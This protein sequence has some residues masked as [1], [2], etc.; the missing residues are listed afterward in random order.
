MAGTDPIAVQFMIPLLSSASELA[1][2]KMSIV[3]VLL[4]LSFTEVS[5]SQEQTFLLTTNS[6]E[7]A[8][9]T[10]TP[11]GPVTNSVRDSILSKFFRIRDRAFD[12]RVWVFRIW[13]QNRE[14]ATVKS[15]TAPLPILLS[16]ELWVIQSGPDYAI[17]IA[18]ALNVF[19]AGTIGGTSES[20]AVTAVPKRLDPERIQ[21]GLSPHSQ[22]GTFLLTEFID[23]NHLNNPQ[24]ANPVGSLPLQS[25]VVNKTQIAFDVS[26]LENAPIRMIFNHQFDLVKM[27][28]NGKELEFDRKVWKG[29]HEKWRLSISDWRKLNR[30]EK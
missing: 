22:P 30:E 28:R 24:L 26:F 11:D 9:V 10:F 1:S 19:R 8:I 21:R 2:R 27:E 18:P 25:I 15:G 17:E 23:E 3:A 4:F 29:I 20:A 6:A 5:Q 16:E 14:F 13:D 12:A 7:S